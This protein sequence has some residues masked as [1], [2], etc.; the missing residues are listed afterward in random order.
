MLQ[1][2]KAMMHP[3]YLVT[4]WA[5][6]HAFTMTLYISVCKVGAPASCAGV[7]GGAL[8]PGMPASAASA[9]GASSSN[10]WPCARPDAF[11]FSSH[12]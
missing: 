4:Q 10:L 9:A 8:R 6:P 12:S 11:S 5:V 7:T 1:L 2:R 3:L